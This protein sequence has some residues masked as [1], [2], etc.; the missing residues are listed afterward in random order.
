LRFRRLFPKTVSQR[1]VYACWGVIAALVAYFIG[2]VIY[3][4]VECRPSK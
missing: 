3:F 4:A 2:F 1:F